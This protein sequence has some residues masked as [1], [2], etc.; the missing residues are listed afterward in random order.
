MKLCCLCACLRARGKERRGK[1]K[2][3]GGKKGEK[4]EKKGKR[5]IRGDPEVLEDMQD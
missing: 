4:E 3:K 5:G 1:R 2:K